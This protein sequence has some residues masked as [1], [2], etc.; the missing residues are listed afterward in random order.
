MCLIDS[1]SIKNLVASLFTATALTPPPPYLSL[2]TIK[3][4]W[5]SE[6]Y[7]KMSNPFGAGASAEGPKARKCELII[8]KQLTYL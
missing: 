7:F 8:M 3:E 5:I 2:S 4:I 6:S 1:K